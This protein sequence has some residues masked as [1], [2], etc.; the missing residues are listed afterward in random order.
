MNPFRFIISIRFNDQGAL[1][2]F[3]AMLLRS[4]SHFKMSKT[5]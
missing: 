3:V 1:V 4:D 2:V 5:N